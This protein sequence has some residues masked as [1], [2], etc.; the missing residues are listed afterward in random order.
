L[1]TLLIDYVIFVACSALIGAGIGA[2]FGEE[3]VAMIQS[4]PEI[5]LGSAM[6]VCYYVLFEGVWARTPAKWLLGTVV[7][8]ED[9]GKPSLGQV[10]GR[11]LCR[12]IPFEALSFLGKRGRGWHD[13]IPKTYVVLSRST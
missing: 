6:L 4:V 10:F 8:D 9:G 11:T 7:V 2:I 5:L 12:F 13:S 1:G 3:G